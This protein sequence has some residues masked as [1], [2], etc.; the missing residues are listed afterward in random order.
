VPLTSTNISGPG[1]N[2]GIIATRVAGAAKCDD[3]VMSNV[4]PS[5]QASRSDGCAKGAQATHAWQV[6]AA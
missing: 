2:G 6:S 5:A 3:A 4:M 1:V